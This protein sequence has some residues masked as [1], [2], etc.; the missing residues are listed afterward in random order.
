MNIYYTLE[1]YDS[2]SYARGLQHTLC[3][4]ALGAG[5]LDCWQYGPKGRK[6]TKGTLTDDSF[7]RISVGPKK[8]A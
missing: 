8:Y 3:S 6:D 4:Y 7:T 2:H 1:R 5:E